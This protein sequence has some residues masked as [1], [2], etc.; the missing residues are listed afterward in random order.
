VSASDAAQAA[1]Q[2][3]AFFVRQLL[4]EAR[5]KGGLLD[6]GFAGGTFAEML[7]EAIAD[8]VAAAGGLGLAD[9]L[10]THLGGHGANDA[11]ANFA[12]PCAPVA[13][14]L[15]SGF[16][17]RIGRDGTEHIHQGLDL[18]APMG[19]PVAAA[20]GGIVTHAGPAGNYGNLVMVRHPDG[21]E[22]RYAHLSAIGVAVGDR[23]DAGQVL[24]KVGSTGLSDGPHL[25]FE[26]RRGGEAI[27][28]ANRVP[29]NGSKTRTTR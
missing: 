8:K 12:L 2:L 25:H 21:L 11:S 18:A 28:P 10:A 27:D 14:T 22:T 29:L 1:T 26:M 6:A 17:P 5:P 20:G 24:G 16:G 7:D 23:V 9:R 4:A 19:T 13:G 3:E 15:T